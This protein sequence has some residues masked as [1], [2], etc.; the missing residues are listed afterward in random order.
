MPIFRQIWN[1]YFRKSFSIKSR[2]IRNKHIKAYFEYLP[3][4]KTATEQLNAICSDTKNLQQ[5]FLLAA[6]SKK[7]S[8]RMFKIWI[9]HISALTCKVIIKSELYSRYLNDL[10]DCVPHLSYSVDHFICIDKK[11]WKIKMIKNSDKWQ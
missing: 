11:K 7:K 9:G 4:R 6:V 3:C 10:S 2:K 8:T 1:I 5:W